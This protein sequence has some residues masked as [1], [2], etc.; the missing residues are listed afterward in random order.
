MSTSSSA[1]RRAVDRG[2]L[3]PDVDRVGV[4][5]LLLAGLRVPLQVYDR[6]IT[7]KDC[8]FVVDSLLNGIRPKG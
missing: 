6:P 3:R 2:E 8:E 7:D 1:L 4:V 5:D